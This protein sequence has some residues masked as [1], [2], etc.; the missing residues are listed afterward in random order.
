MKILDKKKKIVISICFAF[1]VILLGILVTYAFFSATNNNNRHISELDTGNMR[2]RFADNDNGINQKILPEQ[3]IVKKF[4]VENTGDYPASISFNWYKLIN[5]YIN[6]SL[7]YNLSYSDTL[8]GEYTNIVPES[9]VPVATI[10][11]EQNILGELTVPSNKTYYFNL[12]ITLNSLEN[13]DQ[14]ADLSAIFHTKFSIGDPREYIYYGLTINP[15]GGTWNDY[16][17][18]QTYQL[19]FKETMNIEDPT[20]TGYSF[21][22][23][24]VKGLGSQIENSIFKMGF[25]ETTLNAKWTPNK[26][27]VKIENDGTVEEKEVEY[28]QSIQIETP[29]K[30]GHTFTGWNV[31]GGTFENN[32][33]TISEP[34]DVTL[35]ATWK[36][37]DYKYL[38]YHN[39]MNKDGEN[40]T[41]VEADTE[42]GEATYNTQISPEVKTYTGFTSP[43]QKTHTIKAETVYPPA[44]NRI[45]YNY[46]RNRFTLTINTVGGTYPES[47]TIPLYYEET[48]TIEIPTKYGYNFTNWTGVSGNLV[49][50]IFTMGTE[51]A[52]LTA[53]WEPKTVTVTFNA[54]GGSATTDEQATFGYHYN[55]PEDPTYTGYKFVGWFTELTG[56]EQITSKTVVNLNENTTFYAHWQKNGKSEE[57]LE[58]L[59]V[60][61]EKESPDFNYISPSVSSYSDLGFTGSIKNRDVS[62]HECPEYAYSTE[63]SFD[64]I[65]GQ[66]ALVNPIIISSET[67]TTIPV[68]AYFVHAWSKVDDKCTLSTS[69]LVEINKVTSKNGNVISYQTSQV[70]PNPGSNTTGVYSMEDD[71]GTSYYYRGAVENNYVSFANLYWR[72]MRINGDGSLRLVYDGTSAHANGDKAD[73]RTYSLKVKFNNSTNDNRFI[74]YMHGTTST[75]LENAQKNTTASNVKSTLDSMYTSKLSSYA[76]YISDTI[77]CHDRSVH[78]GLGYGSNDTTYNGKERLEKTD[79]TPDKIISPTLKCSNKNDSYTVSDTTNGNG[80]LTYPIGLLTADEVAIAGAVYFVTNE[81][82]YLAR[83]NAFW[84][85]TAFDYTSTGAR[86]FGINMYGALARGVTNQTSYGGVVPVI[87]I[88]QEYALKMTGSGTKSSPYVV[89]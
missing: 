30:E 2:L 77:F 20:R 80:A 68:G 84:L 40:Y 63:Y 52:T 75:S 34:N 10:E 65:T 16:L 41:L 4:Y 32:T 33:V 11:L 69:N 85:M 15:N 22:G 81:Q 46:T 76:K 45:D 24:E 36:I 66:Y 79:D 60:T 18:P 62:A 39:Q 54:N 38:V 21:N 58:Y 28:Q 31:T 27:K 7:S 72:I 61:P 51:D 19:R 5:T 47:T 26:Y 87:N 13:I 67:A 14:T 57:V 29:T 25:Y 8:E 59:K 17:G 89:R 23:W 88:K 71:Y 43:A 48:K 44:L 37:N 64:E 56:G 86:N 78:E 3:T 50:N 73:D 42:E 70:A 1:S 55:L 74:G 49:D 12:A 83:G 53:N 9:N 82:F 6:G 35:V